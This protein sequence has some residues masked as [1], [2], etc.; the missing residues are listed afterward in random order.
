[1][2]KSGQNRGGKS[3]QLQEGQENWKFYSNHKY[4][5]KQHT[6]HGLLHL[7]RSLL[8]TGIPPPLMTSSSNVFHSSIDDIEQRR[9]SFVPSCCSSWSIS[10]KRLCSSFIYSAALLDPYPRNNSALH[11]SIPAVLLDPY[12]RSEIQIQIWII[13]FSIKSYSVK[14]RNPTH[15]HRQAE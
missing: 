15:S 10:E 13:V 7:S 2:G 6:C 8:S 3:C 4:E 9:F 12:P 5:Y 1:M 14:E 11:S